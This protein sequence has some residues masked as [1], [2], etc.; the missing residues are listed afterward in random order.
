MQSNKCCQ[1]SL[2]RRFLSFFRQFIKL[3]IGSNTCISVNI[4]RKITC[5][6]SKSKFILCEYNAFY[7]SEIAFIGFAFYVIQQCIVFLGTPG[8]LFYILLNEG[9]FAFTSEKVGMPQ[10]LRATLT[11]MIQVFLKFV[12][13]YIALVYILCSS[14]QSHSLSNNFIK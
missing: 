4:A 14:S 8:I 3:L 1:F 7:L 6:I 5:Y 13:C 2:M 12:L 11:Y 9:Q 10:K